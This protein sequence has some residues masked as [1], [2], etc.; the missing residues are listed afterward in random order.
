MKNTIF[1][2]KSQLRAQLLDLGL[3]IYYDT[4]PASEVGEC[5]VISHMPIT[6]NNVE[7][8]N[9]IVLFIYIDKIDGK[10]NTRNI[11][12]YCFDISEK[13]RT[14]K[15]SNGF[16]HFNEEQEP[17]T[18]NMKDQTVTTFIFRTISN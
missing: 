1:D 18:G 4:K 2:V 12:Q 5:I 9:D 17:E 13:L 15:A 10:E 6:K 7:S 16:I 11:S 14:F 3:T 8:T